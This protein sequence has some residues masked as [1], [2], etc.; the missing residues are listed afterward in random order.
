MSIGSITIHFYFQKS[1]LGH[2][3]P[4]ICGS[5]GMPGI[6]GV[7]GPQGPKGREGAKGKLEIRDHKECRVQKE[8][9]D[10]EGLPE[11]ADSEESKV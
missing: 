8:T 1:I 2:G 3:F 6:P 11:K 4:G 5:N 7:P 9:E 10:A